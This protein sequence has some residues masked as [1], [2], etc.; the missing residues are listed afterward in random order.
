MPW[1]SDPRTALRYFDLSL[2]VLMTESRPGSFLPAITKP[3]NF[4]RTAMT[5]T[6]FFG[7][8]TIEF[9]FFSTRGSLTTPR[10]LK[11]LCMV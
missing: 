11:S 1:T 9:A 10:S 5:S 6:A 2:L 3:S 4:E 8:P 7:H